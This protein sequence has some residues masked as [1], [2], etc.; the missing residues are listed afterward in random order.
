MA[1]LKISTVLLL[2]LGYLSSISGQ[3]PFDL[4]HRLADSIKHSPGSSI[5]NPE[6]RKPSLDPPPP[7]KDTSPSDTMATPLFKPRESSPAQES[8]DSQEDLALSRQQKNNLI[9]GTFILLVLY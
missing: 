9:F 1:S 7:A 2:C 8:L 3:T 4:N 6:T 5:Q